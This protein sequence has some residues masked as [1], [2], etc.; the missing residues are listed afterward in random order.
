MFSEFGKV[1]SIDMKSEYAFVFMASG[2]NDAIKNLDGIDLHK[3]QIR[4]Q[5]SRGTGKV[6]RR[7]Y[8]A[9]TRPST[10]LF[11][12]NFPAETE[13]VELRRIFEPFG[14]LRR[15]NIRNN[16]CFVEYTRIDDAI[17]AK[18]EVN[19]SD[20]RAR[21]I[22]VE[23]QTDRSRA[24]ESNSRR[25]SR[26]GSPRSRRSYEDDYSYRRRPGRSRSRSR[27]RSRRRSPRYDRY[28][29]SH[30]RY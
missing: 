2:H 25:R 17:R 16:Y 4:V 19:G 8:E 10:T 18:K 30:R 1:T 9:E 23:Y 5:W 12:V 7:R 24:S 11:V 27:S 28:Q 26:S 13:E 3:R 29:D 21:P 15:C 22:V 20:F 14:N 6:K